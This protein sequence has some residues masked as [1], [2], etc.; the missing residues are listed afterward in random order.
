VRGFLF[1]SYSLRLRKPEQKAGANGRVTNHSRPPFRVYKGPG[2]NRSKLRP[3]SPRN[4]KLKGKTIFP[5]L[6][7]LA[8]AT[9]AMQIARPV[10]LTPRQNKRHLWQARR[11]S[12]RLHHDDRIRKGAPPY[13]NTYPSLLLSLSLY[14]DRER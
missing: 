1:P 14:R 9:S 10:A 4:S 2:E 3:N 11:A 8:R 7:R 12:L 5:F 6:K 13:L